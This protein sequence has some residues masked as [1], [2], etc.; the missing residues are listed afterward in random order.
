MIQD[1]PWA[2]LAEAW[3]P[4]LPRDGCEVVYFFGFFI[5]ILKKDLFFGCHLMHRKLS[6]EELG[7]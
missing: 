1:D 6:A 4:K 7:R 3:L 5:D 2:W